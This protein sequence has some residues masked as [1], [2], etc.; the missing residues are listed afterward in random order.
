VKLAAILMLGT[1]ACSGSED[2]PMSPGVEVGEDSLPPAGSAYHGDTSHLFMGGSAE[3]FCGIHGNFTAAIA[4]PATQ[5]DPVTSDYFATFEGH[6]VLEPPLVASAV[7]YPLSL[8]VHMTELITLVGTQ[9]ATRT[10]DTELAAFEL[11]GTA[12]PAGV[13]IR[14]SPTVASPGRT[15]ITALSGGRYRV[16]TYYDVWLELSTDGGGTWIPADNAVHMTLGAPA[17]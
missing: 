6:L 9:G 4:P 15:T 16:E 7:T 1:L 2:E 5:S 12:A 14:E 8:Q 10:F 3:L 13:M 17:G 11:G